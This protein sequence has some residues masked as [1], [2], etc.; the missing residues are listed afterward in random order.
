MT[1]Y[2][3]EQKSI[4]IDLTYRC[5]A[6]CEYCQWGSSDSKG[7]DR[8]LD[9]VLLSKTILKSMEI[10][11]VVFSGGEP[12]L[13][14]NFEEIAKY[15]MEQDVKHIILISNGLLLSRSKFMKLLEVG[16]TGITISFDSIDEKITKITR[17]MSERQQKRIVQNMQMLSEHKKAHNSFEFGVNATLSKENIVDKSVVESIAFLNKLNLDFVKFQPVFNDGYVEN[18]APHLLLN[19]KDSPQL[20]KIGEYITGNLIHFSNPINFYQTLSELLKG[21]L[22]DGST[23]GIDSNQSILINNQIKFC[24]W[25]NNP[26]YGE[27]TEDFSA[28]HVD[29]TVKEF[30]I[31]KKHCKTDM[32]CFCLQKID[33]SWRLK[34]WVRLL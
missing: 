22:L 29:S 4:V 32:Y 34:E 9:E 28:E 10:N 15:Y 26:V 25:I 2:F 23:C 18:N 27:I 11:K 24:Y 12:L 3:E 21:A 17:G 16:I 33:H 14:K 8:P 5:N 1:T 13:H 7:E 19:T 6:H 20:L 30:L 31:E